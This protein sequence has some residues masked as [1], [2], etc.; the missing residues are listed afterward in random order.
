MTVIDFSAGPPSA[1]SIKAAGH[2]GAVLYISDPREPFMTGKNPSRAYLD[3][4]ERHGIKYAFVYQ[5]RGGGGINV[6]DAGRGF[7]GGKA[8]A[9][10]ALRR[11]NDLRCSK[12]PVFFAVDWDVTLAEWNTRVA[13]Y[14]RGAVSKLGKNRVGIYGHSRVIHWAMEDDVV[15]TVAPGR[16]LGWQTLSWSQGEVARDYA[17]L[18]QGTHNV[19][20]PE[21]VKIDI[22]EVFHE[23]WGW[24]P[25]RVETGPVQRTGAYVLTGDQFSCDAVI[26]TP[27]S[28]WRDPHK[29]QAGVFHTTENQD[30]TPPDNVAN[31]QRNPANSSSYNVLVGT[32]GRTIRSNPDNARSWSAGEPG[33]TNAIH[34]SNIGFAARGDWFR[35][36]PQLEANARWAADLHLRYGLP[37]VWLSPDD[38]RAGRRGFTSH[39][40][41]FHGR[42]GPAYRSDPGTNFPHQWVLNRAR[43]LITIP[44][45]GLF[46]AL[47]DEEQRELLTKIRLIHEQLGP[48]PQ[49]GKNAKGQN[50]TL[51]DGVSALRQDVNNLPAR[52]N[53]EDK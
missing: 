2:T 51:V 32:N 17:V 5:F 50:L 37:L 38:L 43:E 9:D 22:N 19:P 15:A 44:E 29:V 42:G 30:S 26:D 35:F 47:T 4:L 52:I 10:L 36:L 3:D 24:Q 11:L 25:V 18:F 40:N 13:D 14:F 27:D 39:G 46:M 28:G 34:L 33:N 31:W 41:W 12:H 45:E 20:G 16:V 23:A 49:L 1:A 21:G 6:G 48:W 8:D 53:N 7:E